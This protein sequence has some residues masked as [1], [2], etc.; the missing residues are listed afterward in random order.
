MREPMVDEQGRD[1]ASE[2][3]EIERE[4]AAPVNRDKRVEPH[5]IEG[6]VSS[7]ADEAAPAVDEVGRDTAPTPAP[8]P[9]RPNRRGL[10]GLLSGALGGLVAAALAAA[11]AYYVLAPK[12]DRAEADASRLAAIEA[13]AQRNDTA[14]ADLAKRV[15][16]LGENGSAS[17][18]A[19]IDKRLETLEKANADEASRIASA[20]QAVQTLSG[21][22]KDLRADV[23]AARGEI[24]GLA[25]RVAKL[26]SA[27]PQAPAAD[28]SG[29]TSRLDKIETQLAAP[30]S[31]SRVAPE[32]PG[33]RDNPAAVAIV[34]ASL[35]DRLNHG[36]PLQTE[37]DGL[38]R[39]GVDP[40]SL[41]PLKAVAGGAPTD[42][43]LAAAFESVR[44]KVLSA[45]APP[46]RAD[47]IANRFLAHLRGLVQVRN[48]GSPSDS[49]GEDPQ[50]LASRIE[51]DCRRGD[52][53]GALAAFAKLP[54]PSREA[55]RTWAEAAESRRAADAAVQS[56]IETAVAQLTK[57]GAP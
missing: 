30:K 12:F 53:N 15:A 42:A 24:P 48:L 22:V 27:P 31:E 36:L 44:S 37:L 18:V 57:S 20:T 19:A 2:T 21:N 23:D 25:A 34:A 8:E 35:R 55:G 32:K 50:A 43:A 3:A 38:E 14:I 52:V 6:D 7:R 28:L 13:E 1:A 11:A 47:G 33:A 40:A 4:A 46:E 49:A 54:E 9:V 17:A 5:V 51:G 16:G 26:E 41:A 29:V 10:G 56:I 45:A 39:L